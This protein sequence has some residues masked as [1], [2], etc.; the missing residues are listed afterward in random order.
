MSFEV[1]MLTVLPAIN[2]VKPHISG[3]R[4]TDFRPNR[5]KTNNTHGAIDFNYIGGQAGA[6]NKSLPF[7]HSPV[8]GKVT[9]AGG[10]YGTVKIE[11]SKGYSHEILHLI[12]IRV[13]EGQ[14]I[15]AGTPIGKMAG[16]GPNGDFQY[17]IHIHYQLRKKGETKNG[18]LIDPVA[19]WN[20]QDQAYTEPTTVT[21]DGVNAAEGDYDTHA[22]GTT[23]PFHYKTEPGSPMGNV[24]EYMPR[25]AGASSIADAQYA[26]WT[27]RVPQHEPWPRTLMVD[28]PN[29][30]AVSDEPDYNVNHEPQ[31]NDT[32]AEGS[33]NINRIEGE[34]EI[35]RGRFWRR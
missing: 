17:A 33:R 31:W 4:F 14:T 9:L 26:L 28:T 1:F 3:S 27:N 25:Q 8:D 22:D 24:E 5:P 32:T 11:D 16:K 35:P 23:D 21:E 6:A 18:G 34:E 29:L 30:N 20:G 2:G 19:F 15:K 10:R 12:K 7:A 13:K